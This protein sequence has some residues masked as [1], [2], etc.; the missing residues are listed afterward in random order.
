M[1]VRDTPFLKLGWKKYA[2][3]F[4]RTAPSFSPS[5]F[6]GVSLRLASRRLITPHYTVLC[7][8]TPEGEQ[9]FLINAFG[10]MY[11]EMTASSFVKINITGELIHPGFSPV[12]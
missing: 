6:C 9:H 2:P 8:G 11:E 5:T 7:R 3:N 10:L 12:G 4:G 1:R